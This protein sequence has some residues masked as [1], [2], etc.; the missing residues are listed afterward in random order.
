[1]GAPD[2]YPSQRDIADLE[3]GLGV[4]GT[5]LTPGQ[6]LF[7]LLFGIV[8]PAL[9][10]VLDAGVFK[11]SASLRPALP[12]YWATTT[13]V[14]AGGL[15]A[16]LAV[17]LLSAARHPLLGILLAGPFAA[18]VLLVLALAARLLPLG[19]TH[20]E[21]LSGMLALTLWLT[22]F[23]FV[24]ETARAVQAACRT[25]VGL[26]V[27]SLV[28][29]MAVVLGSFL[30]VIG[31]I[32][33]RAH[34]LEDLLFSQDAGEHREAVSQI[35]LDAAAVDFDRV[36][37]RYHALGEH[38]PRRPRIAAA[39]YDLRGEPMLFALERLGHMSR[40]AVLAELLFGDSEKDH[41]HAVSGFLRL[42]DERRRGT[43]DHKRRP[44]E[45]MKLDPALAQALDGVV[46]R[47]HTL[48]GD[49]PRRL[50]IATSY[51]KITGETMRGALKRRGL[52]GREA[53]SQERDAVPPP[54][55]QTPDG[56]P[57]P[58]APDA[59]TEPG[60]RSEPRREPRMPPPTD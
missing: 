15:G 21:Y 35:I 12:P 28:L 32:A 33:H 37:D 50:R 5:T 43:R 10:L 31:S 7:A 55:G 53:P 49:D 11:G 1:M 14:A 18:A 22:L 27:V 41:K 38:D 48:P 39:Y 54:P 52:L 30:A 60:T 16:A 42:R 46:G 45:P 20:I 9:L 6:F 51:L 40:T 4:L 13:Y 34:A 44:G 26:A 36:V 57:P 17:W 58:A 23:V 47:F 3:A 29:G 24:R 59:R 8:T 25:S 56:S 19:V 2:S